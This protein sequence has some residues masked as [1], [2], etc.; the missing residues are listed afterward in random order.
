MNVNLRNSL[1][2]ICYL[3]TTASYG[4]HISDSTVRKIDSLFARWNHQDSPGL[5]VGVVRNDS[6]IFSKGYGMANLEY[7]IQ[8]SA[9]TRFYIASVSKQFTGYCIILLARKKKI[10]LDE[11][12]RV[13]LPWFPD[14]KK[15]ITVR[16]LLNH[17]SGIRDHL[18][19]IAI[20][21]LSIDGVLTNELV[22][23]T[24]QMQQGLNFDPGTRYSYS[25]SNYIV[26]TEI[27][28]AVSKK[29]FRHFADSAIFAPLR[30]KETHF[31][32]NPSE[33]VVDRAMSY[34]RGSDGSYSNAFQNVY[35][36]GDGGMFTT[37]ADASKWITNFYAP[38]AGDAQDIEALTNTGRLTTGK[39]LSY[40]SGI[41]ISEENGWKV[42][43]HGGSLHAYRAHVSI[44]PELKMGFIIFANT[45]ERDVQQS[46]GELARLFVTSRKPR[47]ER[48]PQ[49]SVRSTVS[50]KDL[51][52][53][54]KYVGDY[55]SDDGYVLTLKWHDG[56]LL[57]SGFGQEFKVVGK[58]KNNVYH[59]PSKNNPLTKIVFTGDGKREEFELEFPD[60]IL[61]FT[62]FDNSVVIDPQKLAGAYYC[63]ELDCT[64][65]IAVRNGELFLLHSKYPDSKLTLRETHLKRD[66]WFMSHMKIMMNQDTVSGFE[67]NSGNVM[68]LP[69]IKVE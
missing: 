39:Q 35:T 69:F 50:P 58:E 63:A 11:D 31:H 44:Y 57:G 1:L 28:K 2:T 22:V 59:F 30:M 37:V 15:K 67:V 29:P 41:R 40:A 55:V 8:I 7:G 25:N 9:K 21:G 12:I 5:A 68:H 13:Y 54:K 34:W 42:Y 56:N 65:R 32:D 64:Y 6:L 19:L 27:V 48:S 23:K 51:A 18:N 17:T 33:L 53:I 46:I 60:E 16:N 3:L 14:L 62:K 36:V 38:T 4:Q 66:S 61:H 20:S 24:L 43:S 45:T 10:N 47:N 52:L 49:L 26:L